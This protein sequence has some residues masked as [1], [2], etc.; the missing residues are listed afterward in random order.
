VFRLREGGGELVFGVFFVLNFEPGT[1]ARYG[2]EDDA[3]AV[4][5]GVGY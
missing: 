5:E 1:S 3:I 4:L 2:A